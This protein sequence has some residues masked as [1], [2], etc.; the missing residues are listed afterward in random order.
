MN[1]PF[2]TVD[3]P[4]WTDIIRCSETPASSRS[5]PFPECG[6]SWVCATSAAHN[7][8]VLYRRV[9]YGYAWVSTIDQKADMQLQAS[10]SAGV[11]SENIFTDERECVM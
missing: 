9:K 5:T 6:T 8:A 2:H 10:Q 7:E 4:R 3:D 11:E 1:C